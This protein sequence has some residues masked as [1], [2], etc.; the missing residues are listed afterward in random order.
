M[1]LTIFLQLFNLH[2]KNNYLYLQLIKLQLTDGSR[3][4]NRKKQYT[5]PPEAKKK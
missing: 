4:G 5:L 2:I 3:Q 1:S